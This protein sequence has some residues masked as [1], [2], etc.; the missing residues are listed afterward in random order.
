VVSVLAAALWLAAIHEASYNTVVERYNLYNVR[1]DSYWLF[2]RL[3]A[4]YCTWLGLWESH[5]LDLG[6]L[7]RALVWLSDV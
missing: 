2:S 3:C 6:L 5:S 4:L 7:A 1:I